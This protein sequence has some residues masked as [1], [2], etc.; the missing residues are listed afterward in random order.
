MTKVLSL[1]SLEVR[2][3]VTLRRR[4]GQSIICKGSSHASLFAC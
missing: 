3:S 2:E 4:S 1:Q